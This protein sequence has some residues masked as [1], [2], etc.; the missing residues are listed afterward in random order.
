[1]SAL[2]VILGLSGPKLTAAERVFFR[3]AN[4]WGFILFSRNVETPEQVYRLTEELREA[5]GRN[6][7]IFIDQEGG[8]V[9]RLRPPHWRSFPPGAAFQYLY[10]MEEPLGKRAAY[11]SYRL[12]ADDLRNVGITADCAPVLDLPQKSADPIISDRAFGNKTA[13]I[14]DIANA[15]M[16]GLM[17]GG[18]APVI[19]HIPGHGRATVDSH[20]ELPKIK[21]SRQTLERT[22]FIPF[23]ALSDAPMAMTA[24]A[25]YE[26]SSRSAVTV[27]K[28]SMTELVR[29]AIGFNGLVMSD[30]LDMK[31]L[32]GGLKR[33][34]E[35]ALA[36]GCDIAL[37]CSGKLPDM[38][39]VAKGAKLLDG[40]AEGR[41][42]IAEHCAD[43]IKPFDRA[44]V[45][46]EFDELISLV[47]E[48]KPTAERL[49]G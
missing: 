28:K 10:S 32:K 8:R 46:R 26:C 44:S 47:P 33:K 2:A 30:D 29:A 13:P 11:L 16:A 22:D 20:K 45:E 23:R 37:Q 39:N 40:R 36:A 17:C 48:L 14:I 1:M 15:A 24:H 6:C 42:L 27:S 25:V 31:A 34:T 41:A 18:V 5:V 12:I 3:D 35:R 9:Q 21:T 38:V 4:P 7:L 19:K 49:A 43:H